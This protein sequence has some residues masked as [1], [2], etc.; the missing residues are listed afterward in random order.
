MWLPVA[1]PWSALSE[2]FYW[3]IALLEKS[4]IAQKLLEKQLQMAHCSD[5]RMV[6]KTA[7]KVSGQAHISTQREYL[8]K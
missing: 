1:Q 7:E 8:P 6:G 2:V 4:S 3:N 5:L